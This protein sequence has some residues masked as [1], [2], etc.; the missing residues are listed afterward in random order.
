MP[1]STRSAV[2]WLQRAHLPVA[3]GLIVV[4]L[5]TDP[6]I[7]ADVTYLVILSATMAALVLRARQHC[8][9]DARPWW[10]TTGGTAVAAATMLAEQTAR[11]IGAAEGLRS[12]IDVSYVVGFAVIGLGLRQ[13]VVRRTPHTDREGVVDGL[14]VATTVALVF[15][16]LVAA[17]PV[18][19]LDP[20]TVL[21]SASFV[22]ALVAGGAIALC[23]RL[24]FL[25]PRLPAAWVLL[26]AAVLALA[27]S[28][29]ALVVVQTGASTLTNRYLAALMMG[30]LTLLGETALRPSAAQLTHPVDATPWSLPRARLVLLGC[31]LMVT[32]VHQ[33]LHDHGRHGRWWLDAA[34]LVLTALVI[35]QVA[36]LVREREATRRLARDRERKQAGIA[37]LGLVAVSDVGTG[38]LL[39]R[40]AEVTR[41]T[42]DAALV[43]ISMTGASDPVVSPVGAHGVP[44]SDLSRLDGH[45]LVRLGRRGLQPHGISAGGLACDG[46]AALGTP[47]RG[48]HGASGVLLV[49]P[50]RSRRFTRDEIDFLSSVGAMLASAV[51]R[52]RAEERLR[53]LAMYDAL[54][55]LPNRT[56][57]L[58]RLGQALATQA[59]TQSR[60]GVLFVDLDGFKRVNDTLGHDAGDQLLQQAAARIR[61]C[62]RDG[63]TARLAG[64]EFVVMVT[65]L[66]GPPAIH[67]VAERVVG[68]LEAPFELQ[69]GTAVIGASVGVVVADD[70]DDAESLLRR[71]DRAMYSAKRGGKGRVAV[72]A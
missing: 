63:E 25:D 58:D 12:V 40:A 38:E 1:D 35:V 37:S 51:E 3:V 27:W 49:F 43:Q 46:L 23:L 16:E 10:I 64:D 39:T 65:G 24:V 54:T 8:G 22:I 47:I 71:A 48:R 60:L 7:V 50:G 21:P 53:Y 61:S 69:A 11:Y 59:R 70:D 57:F 36:G 56:L 66:P 32:P 14:I 19:Q 44:L 6:V 45:D 4:T 55:T 68:Q 30:A 15:G 67:A 33:L 52:E 31:A 13:L 34:P 41:T 9:D 5:L 28:A 72:V 29:G 17:A 18:S 42:L 26:G 62:V 2:A 20:T